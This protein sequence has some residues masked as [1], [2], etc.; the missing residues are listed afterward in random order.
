M[1]DWGKVLEVIST[2]NAE[3][4]AED[5]AAGSA[6]PS[7]ERLFLKEE[8]WDGPKYLRYSHICRLALMRLVL[9]LLHGTTLSIGPTGARVL[10]MRHLI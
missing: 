10:S 3:T 1:G 4:A 9:W 2:E 6:D 8:G 7:D 5:G